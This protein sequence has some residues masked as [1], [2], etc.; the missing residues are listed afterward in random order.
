[1][2]MPFRPELDAVYQDLEDAIKAENFEPIRLDHTLYTGD[3][4]ATVKRLLV[5]AEGIV[6]EVTDDSPNVMYELGYAH[7]LARNPLLVWRIQA[8]NTEPPFYLKTQRLTKVTGPLELRAE[9]K[10]YFEGVRSGKR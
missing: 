8:T 7:A 10:K 4:P 6:A 3:I 9:M 1:M 2:L 5:E